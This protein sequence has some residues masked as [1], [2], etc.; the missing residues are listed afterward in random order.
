LTASKRRVQ[1]ICDKIGGKN[2]KIKQQETNIDASAESRFYRFW[3]KN[4]QA[5]FVRAMLFMY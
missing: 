5:L 4:L 2:I 3:R 1:T